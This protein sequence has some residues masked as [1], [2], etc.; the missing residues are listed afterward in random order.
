MWVVLSYQGFF[1][2]LGCVKEYCQHLCNSE[3]SLRDFYSTIA[4]P[5]LSLCYFTSQIEEL[6][7]VLPPSFSIPDTI[8]EFPAFGTSVLYWRYSLEPIYI[9]VYAFTLWSKALVGIEP[10]LILSILVANAES[11]SCKIS[12]LVLQRLEV[13]IKILDFRLLYNTLQPGL[14]QQ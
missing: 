10:D 1:W 5:H 4:S 13:W 11:C 9:P 2:I 6:L 7:S 8:A 3:H 12:R 14:W